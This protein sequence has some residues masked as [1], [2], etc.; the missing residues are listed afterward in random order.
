MKHNNTVKATGQ[1]LRSEG[2]GLCL[3]MEA[4]PMTKSLKKAF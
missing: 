3:K 2:F 4:Y 1:M